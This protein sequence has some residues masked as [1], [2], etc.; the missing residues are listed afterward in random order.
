MWS[1]GSHPH[2]AR[3]ALGVCGHHH[4]SGVKVLLYPV[5]GASALPAVQLYLTKCRVCWMGRSRS[6]RLRQTSDREAIHGMSS[7]WE[8]SMSRGWMPRRCVPMKD[9]A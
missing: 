2:P 6:E 5:V 7:C 8:D 3:D 9:V 1:F 4:D